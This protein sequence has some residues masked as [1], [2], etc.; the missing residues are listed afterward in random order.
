MN[1]PLNSIIDVGT[2]FLLGKELLILD[3]DDETITTTPNSSFKSSHSSQPGSH[4]TK[5]ISSASTGV[6]FQQEQRQKLP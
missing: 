2:A 3:K 4:W 1:H 6:W 5:L